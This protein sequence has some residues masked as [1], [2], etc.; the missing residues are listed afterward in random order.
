MTARSPYDGQPSLQASREPGHVALSVALT[1]LATVACV[2]AFTADLQGPLRTVATLGFAL[3]A[4]GL[5]LAEF[6]PVRGPAQRLSVATGASLGLETIIAV[7]LVYA[8][9]YSAGRTLAIVVAVTLVAV[10]AA[11]VR[12]LR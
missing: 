1:L 5:A 12:A 4:P 11:L 2:A 10:V 8:G 6:L 7:S 3:F 9:A